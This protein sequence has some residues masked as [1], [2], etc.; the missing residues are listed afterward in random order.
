MMIIEAIKK[1]QKREHLTD[2]VMAEK[3][4]IHP[5]SWNRIKNERA[6]FGKNLLKNAVHEWPELAKTVL[7]WL[8]GDNGNREH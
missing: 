5:I 3:L 2:V 8:Y 7:D 4:G 6:G 1:I